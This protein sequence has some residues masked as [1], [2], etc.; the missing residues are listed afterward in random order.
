M[1]VIKI[2]LLI[3]LFSYDLNTTAQVA[4]NKDSTSPASDAILQV[5]GDSAGT[6]VQ[7]MFIQLATG[8]VGIGTT[9][10][11]FPLTFKDLFGDKISLYG[12][13]DTSMGFGVQQ[14]LLQILGRDSASDIAFGYGSSASF[15]ELLRVKG[16]GQVSLGSSSPNPSALLEMSSTTKG[17]LPPRVTTAEMNAI[18]SPAE[19]LCVYNI[20]TNGL[21]YYT[22]SAWYCLDEQSL[23]THLFIC[24]NTYLDK[25]TGYSFSTVKIGKQCWMAENLN[26]GKMIGAAVDQTNNDTVEK[27]CYYNTP[28]KCALYGGLYQWNEM[29]NYATTE[30]AQ[31]ICPSGW[32]IP[33]NTDWTTLTNYLGGLSVAGG[34]MKE[35][36]TAHWNSPNTGANNSSSFTALPGGERYVDVG[37]LSLHSKGFLWSSSDFSTNYGW[38]RVLRS[39]STSIGEDAANY[40]TAISVRCVKD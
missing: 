22:D 40:K 32:H 38:T 29:M 16:N 28:A 13:S 21:C 11:G 3:L 19:G 12:Q 23:C 33:S 10:P 14:N 15:T 25:E 26:I 27:Y 6:P 18:A 7:A 35:A 4:I 30:E 5:K 39:D 8:N 34:K 37:F 1:K 20:D 2:I 17:F 36:G 9:T 31:G 24:G